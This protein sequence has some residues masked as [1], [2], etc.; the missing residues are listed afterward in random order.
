MRGNTTGYWDNDQLLVVNA[1]GS[2]IA[3]GEPV[4]ITGAVYVMDSSE[5]STTVRRLPCVEP[6]L[7]HRDQIFDFNYIGVFEK[8]CPSSTILRNATGTTPDTYDT[9]GMKAVTLEGIL[10][11]Y[12]DNPGQVTLTTS[13][14]DSIFFDFYGGPWYVIDA[15]NIAAGVDLTDLL[16]EGRQLG[17]LCET[18]AI[19]AGERALVWCFIDQFPR[20]PY[21]LWLLDGNGI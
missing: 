2:T 12:V 5:P 18:V 17:V 21:S 13:P 19:A 7:N 14:G 20:I 11:V 6:I 4:A 16:P 15:Y 9:A 1:S 3:H 8:D 10:Q